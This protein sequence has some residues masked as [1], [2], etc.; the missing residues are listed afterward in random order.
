M[1]PIFNKKSHPR[2]GGNSRAQSPKK[3]KTGHQRTIKLGDVS[4]DLE[5]AMIESKVSST[6]M[7]NVIQY[8]DFPLQSYQKVQQYRT[9]GPGVLQFFVSVDREGFQG[10]LPFLQDLTR[11]RPHKYMSEHDQWKVVSK[12]LI[13]IGLYL[14]RLCSKYG[15]NEQGRRRYW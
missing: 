6:L 13:P 5:K 11:A 8:S 4:D 2:P 3:R 14:E 9:G 1:Y 12:A 10:L 15:V 7:P